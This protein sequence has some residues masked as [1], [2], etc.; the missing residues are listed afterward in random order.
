MNPELGLVSG[1]S[2]S[3]SSGGSL[4]DSSSSSFPSPPLDVKLRSRLPS[5]DKK[6]NAQISQPLACW[7]DHVFSFVLNSQAGD[8]PGDF[9]RRSQRSAYKIADIWHVRYRRLNTPS[10]PVPAIFYAHHCESPV[11][12]TNQVRRFYHMTSQNAPR[13]SPGTRFKCHIAAI[14]EKNRQVCPHQSVAIKFAAI[15]V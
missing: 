6:T 14:S 13:W 1:S 15:G 9:I 3:S 8:I 12:S 2:S 11:K 5:L 10:V 7:C 4:K